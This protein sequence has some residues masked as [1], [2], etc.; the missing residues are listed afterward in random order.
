MSK[1]HK[2]CVAS[3]E[4]VGD[5]EKEEKKKY[6]IKM[7]FI[8]SPGSKNYTV[9]YKIKEP[10]GDLDVSEEKTSYEFTETGY[11]LAISKYIE[12]RD[13]IDKNKTK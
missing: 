11:G 10:F 2:Q 1:T 12:Y 13:L 3:T 5:V 4:H 6:E 7:Y 8:D 9:S